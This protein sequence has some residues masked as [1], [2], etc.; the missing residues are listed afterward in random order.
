MIE[1]ENYFARKW[2]GEHLSQILT[3]K[4]G[5]R[6]VFHG[7]INQAVT[8]SLGGVLQ[9]TGVLELMD[10]DIGY[11]SSPWLMTMHILPTRADADLQVRNQ[12]N[13]IKSNQININQ[14]TEFQYITFR[15]T[16]VFGSIFV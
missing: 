11:D 15:L 2:E 14:A 9:D 5:A 7:E 8:E 4:V 12:S 6:R 10:F 16:V 13:R 3:L 1:V